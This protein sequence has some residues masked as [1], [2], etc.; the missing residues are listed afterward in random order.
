MAVALRAPQTLRYHRSQWDSSTHKPEL[1]IFTSS[2]M[3]WARW[4]FC[5]KTRNEWIFLQ[6]RLRLFSPE[7]FCVVIPNTLRQSLAVLQAALED[8]KL[9]IQQNCLAGTQQ[10]KWSWKPLYHL[11]HDSGHESDLNKKKAVACRPHATRKTPISAG[12]SPLKLGKVLTTLHQ[13]SCTVPHRNGIQRG[14]D[15]RLT[16]FTIHCPPPHQ[17]ESE[18]ILTVKEIGFQCK[19]RTLERRGTWKGPWPPPGG[20]MVSL[21]FCEGQV[22]HRDKLPVPFKEGSSKAVVLKI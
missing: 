14:P 18:R 3:Y 19:R 21:L 4:P 1:P 12:A 6:T 15:H 22:A 5:L 8:V 2:S 10:L 17:A 7:F 9:L 20:K 11:F 13:Y 16:G